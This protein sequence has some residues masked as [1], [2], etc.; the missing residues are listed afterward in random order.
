MV[1]YNIDATG[2]VVSGDTICFTEGVF[3]GS[4][5]RPKFVGNRVIKAKVLKDSYGLYKQQHTFTLEVIASSGE[6]PIV[7]G[8]KIRRKGRNVYRNG[9]MRM[10]WK[11]ESKR[12]IALDEK[13]ERGDDA[14]MARESRK[15]MKYV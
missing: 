13:H 12:K 10:P 8:K 7:K 2:D 6:D 3:A 15:E 11:D 1:K 4:Y 14:R 5:R 9:V